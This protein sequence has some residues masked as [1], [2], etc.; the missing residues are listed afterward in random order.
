MLTR[1]AIATALGIQ[2]TS[3]R[4]RVLLRWFLHANLPRRPVNHI[5]R[6]MR[7]RWMFI[8]FCIGEQTDKER[9]MA[10]EEEYRY[11]C[12]RGGHVSVGYLCRIVHEITTAIRTMPPHFVPLNTSSTV[13]QAFFLC[14]ICC[15]TS[16]VHLKE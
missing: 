13:V 14:L 11:V 9:S 2:A 10:I 16:R 12:R 15:W 8:A 3:E 7:E 5:G 1:I 6:P 4:R